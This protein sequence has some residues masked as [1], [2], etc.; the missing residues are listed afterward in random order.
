MRIICIGDSLTFGQG[1]EQKDRWT[2][3]LQ[4]EIGGE[5]WVANKGVCGDTTL[6]GLERFPRDVQDLRPDVVVLQFGHNDANAWETDRGL[7]RV[8]CD[9]YVA[10]LREMIRRAVRFGASRVIVSLPYPT[11]HKGAGY[12]ERL[13]VYRDAAATMIGGWPAVWA[14]WLPEPDLLPDGI[15]PSVAGHAAMAREVEGLIF[16]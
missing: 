10:N 12:R 4:N 9:V 11:D 5:H 14:A 1:V 15:H 3:V 6:L 7:P 13:G 8:G 16:R 2:A